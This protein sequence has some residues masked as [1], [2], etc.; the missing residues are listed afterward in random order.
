MLFLQTLLYTKIFIKVNQ[1]INSNKAYKICY[2]FTK[3]CKYIKS[4]FKQQIKSE[5]KYCYASN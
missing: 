3:K 4:Y 1:V 5:A 2:I